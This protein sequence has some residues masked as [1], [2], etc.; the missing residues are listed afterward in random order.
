MK[1]AAPS[2][3][4][5]YD[6]FEIAG[7]PWITYS[8]LHY[9]QADVGEEVLEFTRDMINRDAILE[10]I[11]DRDFE[12]GSCLVRLP[13]P[14]AYFIG[15]I[16]TEAEFLAIDQIVVGLRTIRNSLGNS[17]HRVKVKQFLNDSILPIELAHQDS[18][19]QVAR[20]DDKYSL[21]L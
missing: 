5:K 11:R 15:R 12:E 14:L 2:L 16:V 9:R 8:A 4:G 7:Y 21:Q 10:M 17:D 19:V 13:L 20:T 18:L 6:E 3:T 1:S